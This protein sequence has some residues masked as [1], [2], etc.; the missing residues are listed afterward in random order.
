MTANDTVGNPSSDARGQADAT[1]FAAAGAAVTLVGVL[2]GVIRSKVIALNLGPEGLGV[3]AATQ[4]L[5]TLCT[6][7]A[8]VASGPALIRWLVNAR[9]DSS[10]REAQRGTASALMLALY[11]SSAG[12]IVAVAI[13]PWAV[14][15]APREVQLMTAALGLAAVFGA[16]SAVFATTFSAEARLGALSWSSLQGGVAGTVLLSLGVLVL[17]A[18]GQYLGTIAGTLVSA[19]ISVLWARRSELFEWPTWNSA[20]ARAA[21]TIGATSLVSIA[22]GHGSNWAVR[23]AL[24]HYGGSLGPYWNGQ[25]QATLSIAGQYFTFIVGSLGTYYYPRFAAASDSS[26]LEAEVRSAARLVLR[27]GPPIVLALVALSGPILTMLYSN[28]FAAAAVILGPQLAGDIPRAISWTYA[29]PLLYRGRLRAFVVTE[30][31]GGLLMGVGSVLFVRRFGLEGVGVGY[32][33]TYLVYLPLTAFLLRGAAGVALSWREL[34][35]ALGFCAVLSA[36]DAFWRPGWWKLTA[37]LAAA[38]A[39]AVFTG[40]AGEFIGSLRSRITRVLG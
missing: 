28:R 16:V 37:F 7:I 33:V 29:G 2:S 25:Y 15:A 38:L 12:A 3:F 19:L 1:S 18:P 5:V 4:Q 10:G 36:A 8:T 17:G 30:M 39:W 14:A 24:G 6:G 20:Y 40:V 11:L 31:A 9:M 27:I 22:L 32:V 13:S 23:Y 35:I 26:A 21:L 34:G